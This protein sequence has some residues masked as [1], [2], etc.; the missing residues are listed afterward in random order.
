V[1]LFRE[2]QPEVSAHT[3]FV[4]AARSLTAAVDEIGQILA[5]TNE[6]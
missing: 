1:E 4:M 2:I 3:N 5:E 6:S